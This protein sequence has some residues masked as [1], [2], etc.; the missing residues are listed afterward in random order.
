MEALSKYRQKVNQMEQINNRFSL[1]K[2]GLRRKALL[3]N[4]L[5]MLAIVVVQLVMSLVFLNAAFDSDIYYVEQG[6]D[7]NI[8]T[9]VETVISALEANHQQHLDGL[10]SEEDSMEIA[11]KIVRDTRYGST[12]DKTDDGYFWADMADGY[13]VVHYNPANQGQM[14]L[15]WVD[16]EGTYF[17]RDFIRLGDAGGGYSDFYFGKPGDE[18]G[19]HRKRGYTKK[20]EP[21]G[22]YISTGNYYEDTDKVIESITATNSSNR[23]VLLG[24]SLFIVIIGLSLVSKNLNRVVTPIIKISNRVHKL[25]MGDTST[26]PFAVT[27]QEDEIGDLHKSTV[28][29]ISILHKLLEDINAMIA[30]H[31]KGNIDYKLNTGEFHGDYKILAK[32]VL[33]LADSGMRDQLTGIPNRRSFNNRLDLE[34]NRAIREKTPVSILIIDV[35]KFKEYNDTYGHQQGDTALKIVAKTLKQSI[36]RSVDFVARWG[37]EEFVALLPATKSSGAVIVAEKI[38]TAIE[39]IIIPCDNESGRSVTISIGVSTQIPSKNITVRD[40]ISKADGALYQAKETG[41]NRVVLN[42]GDSA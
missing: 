31:E 4:G 8:K 2:S 6:F 12:M 23:F 28:E 11:K 27:T 39:S 25:S 21:Y 24:I 19:S 9:A 18:S 10:I 34:W 29:V 40:L 33:E 35:D 36:K 16:Q 5:F 13:C 41:R 17:I 15:D 20:F 42:A 30:E 14:R 1:F 7:T 26:G 22:W 37:G 3:L 32:S 38:R